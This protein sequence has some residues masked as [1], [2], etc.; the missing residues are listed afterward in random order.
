M[1]GIDDPVAAG[2]STC[3]KVQLSNAAGVEAYLYLFG[4][5]GHQFNVDV[6]TYQ[7]STG[8]TVMI[9]LMGV[10]IQSEYQNSSALKISVF[11]DST[12]EVGS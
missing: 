2:R 1:T 5:I 6:T 8:K 3:T 7:N 10:K 12:I 9:G 11:N 4:A